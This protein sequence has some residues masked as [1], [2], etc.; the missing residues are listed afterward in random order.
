VKLIPSE[1]NSQFDRTPRSVR[2]LSEDSHL[3]VDVV[4]AF[5]GPPKTVLTDDDLPIIKGARP[6][7]QADRFL[8]LK[9]SYAVGV[10]YVEEGRPHAAEWDGEIK[11]HFRNELRPIYIVE[12]SP[13][14]AKLQDWQ[15]GD[16][17]EIK[18]FGIISLTNEVDVL[19]I[20]DRAFWLS[21]KRVLIDDWHDE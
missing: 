11:Q 2:V 17:Q 15:G 20:F 8:R 13:W 4:P 3:C 21:N 18:H 12:D 1:H 5:S 9:F 7:L 10:S 14:R 6:I 16:D 19:G